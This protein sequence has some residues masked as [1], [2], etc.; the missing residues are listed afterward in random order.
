MEVAADG[1]HHH[2]TGVQ[3]DA[4][5]HV[6]SLVPQQLLGVLADHLLHV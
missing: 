3:A 6:G 2:L 1:P 5:L 4:D